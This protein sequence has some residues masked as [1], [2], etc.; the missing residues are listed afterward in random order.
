MTH[1][2]KYSMEELTP[3][4]RHGSDNGR[5]AAVGSSARRP[6][7]W[8]SA[9]VIA[10]CIAGALAAEAYFVERTYED[11]VSDITSGLQQVKTA[12]D[13]ADHEAFLA[14]AM[15][16]TWVHIGPCNEQPPAGEDHADTKRRVVSAVLG[17]DPNRPLDAAL[18]EMVSVI[19]RSSGGRPSENLCRYALERALWAPRAE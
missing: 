2:P 9:I 17:A 6:L 3:R 13:L 8:G 19:T 14:E 5:Q 12:R 18:L 1:V 7:F 16:A 4:R 11:F 15:A 10:Y